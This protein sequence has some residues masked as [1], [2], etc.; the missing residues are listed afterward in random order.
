MDTEP[1]RLLL[2]VEDNDVDVRLVRRLIG[3][4]GLRVGLVHARHGEEALSILRDGVPESL[5]PIPFVVLLDLNMPRM[6]GL[7]LIGALDGSDLLH[8][9]SVHVLTTSNNP[10]DR[11][12]V[13]RHGCVHGY[14]TK[15]LD[16]DTLL[17]LLDPEGPPRQR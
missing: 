9:A 1:K 8:D 10:T 6:T 13:A 12:A 3:R 16:A 4:L 2:L 7:D 17:S 15:P 5:P 14:L 11:E